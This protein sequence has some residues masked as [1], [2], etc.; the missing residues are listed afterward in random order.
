MFVS[1]THLPQLLENRHYSDPEIHEQE[2]RQMFQPGWHCLAAWDQFKNDG[3]YLT[4]ELF[5][6]P[7]ILWRRQDQIRAYL[8]VCTHRFSL[9]TDQP[10][11]CF[12]SHMKCQ[13]HGWEYDDDGNTCKIPDAQSFRPL[14]KGELGLKEYRVEMVGQLVFVTLD[15]NAPPLQEYLGPDLSHLCSE[16][17]SRQHHITY[18]FDRVHPCNWKIVI[19]NLLESYH[20]ENVHPKTFKR[21]PVPEHCT[22]TFHDTYDYYIHDYQDEP[23]NAS[24]ERFVC[25]LT[26]QPLDLKWRH[27][28]RY[29]NI[30]VGG[31]GPYYYFLIVFPV[32]PDACRIL[33]YTMHYAGPRGKWWP[34]LVHRALKRYGT[35]I[36]RQI[37]REDAAIYPGIQIG[38]TSQERPHGGGLISAR[39][40]RIFAFQ[41]HILAQL[42]K[43]NA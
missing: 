23:D 27:I 19:E 10:Q 3:D 20:I 8:N 4:A 12:K 2:L 39:E 37:N 36:G 17:F 28:L 1:D 22:H 11:G 33:S 9:L 42:A 5:G 14:K 43:A 16:R 38:N 18:M 41:K 15:P 35:Y 24:A 6:A 32:A 21:F 26:G 25:R 30:A 40:E 29:P 34:F 13:Y 31:S 7:L